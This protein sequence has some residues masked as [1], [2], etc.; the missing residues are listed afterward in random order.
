VWTSADKD[1]FRHGARPHEPRLVHA[2]ARAVVLANV[3]VESLRGQ[4]LAVWVRYDSA[5]G[6]D[7]EHDRGR[8][9][10]SSLVT[11]GAGLA[12]DA[13]DL[14]CVGSV[15]DGLPAHSRSDAGAGVRCW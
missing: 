2:L 12:S 10:G 6:N 9:V 13:G 15:L 1:G 8:T 7:G 3:R 5:L 4:R 14:A 11:R